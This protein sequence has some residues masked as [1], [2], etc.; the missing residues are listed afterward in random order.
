MDKT[1]PTVDN[2]LRLKEIFSVTLDE[3]LCDSDE[4]RETDTKTLESYSFK[5]KKETLSEILAKA[6]TPLIIR[7]ALFVVA[8]IFLLSFTFIPSAPDSIIGLF[9]ACL[10]YGSVQLFNQFRTTLKLWKP[11]KLK[12]SYN[13]Y[14][15]DIYKDHF[16]LSIF[17]NDEIQEWHKVY[18]D[19]IIK[20]KNLKS[21]LILQ[22]STLNFVFEKDA[23][24]S[25]SILYDLYLPKEKADEK[26]PPNAWNN[27]S[28]FLFI[29][30]I[31]AVLG[32]VLCLTLGEASFISIPEG[33]WIFYLFLPIP[34]GS[35]IFGFVSKKKGYS[36]VKNIIIGFIMSAI[37]LIFGSFSFI[38]SNTYSHDDGPI[39]RA[40]ETLNIDIPEHK[41]I[42]T[43]NWTTGTQTVSRGYIYSTSN[44]YFDDDA[45]EEFENNLSSDAKWLSSIP[46]NLIGITSSYID[47]HP[48]NYFIIYN[49]D[50]SEFNQ[51]PS[52]S[53]TYEFIN[54]VY[55]TESNYMTLVDYRIEYTK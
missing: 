23:L 50:T 26:T 30:S 29:F 7:S 18:F 16:V 8:M 9:F 51:L 41:N 35:L 22:T 21:I 25:N 37:L 15:F 1:L 28:I 39:L 32:G 38:F 12:M 45:V 42:N 33:M 2:L 10:I 36:F 44:I 14:C 52:E 47:G 6:I 46:N 13:L 24:A 19:E 11:K 27:A 49:K 53:G 55:N 3:L 17:K 4:D 20:A 5:Y 43:M 48:G 34:I 31:A 54:I 40:E